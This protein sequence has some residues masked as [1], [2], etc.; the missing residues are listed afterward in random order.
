MIKFLSIKIQGFCSIADSLQLNLNQ[1]CT[2]LIKA[3]NGNG[4]TTLFSAIVWALYG[5][6]LKGISDVNTWTNVRPKDYSG[7]LVELFF[8]KGGSV[9]KVVRCQNCSLTLDD[10]AKGKDRLLLFKDSELVNVKGKIK[11]QETI[12]MELGLSYG[13]F[14]NS[15]MFGQGMKRLIQESNSDKKALFEEIFNLNFLNVAK[16]VAINNKAI[17]VESLNE[18]DGKCDELSRDIESNSAAYRDL[19]EVEKNFE[20]SIKEEREELMS[21][22]L[23]LTNRLI[24]VNGKYSEELESQ[25]KAKKVKRDKSLRKL[26]DELK[27]A[28][29]I[30]NT[31]LIDVIDQVYK[32][33]KSHEYKKA[34]SL[35]KDIRSAIISMD[36]LREQISKQE[37]L[38]DSVNQAL[39]DVEKYKRLASDIC[40]DI[41][42][43]D[44]QLSQLDNRKPKKL[45]INY[46]AKI[47]KLKLELKSLKESQ[48]RVNLET[49]LDNYNWLIQDP[50]GNNG[51]KAYLFDSSL[52]MV[53]EALHRY[54]DVLGFNIEFCIDLSTARKEFVTLI[55]RDGHIINY[56]ELS[57][58]ER[59]VCNIAMAFA[60]NEALTASKGIN[61]AFLD[62]V[63]ESLSHDN[64][65]IVISLINKV[66]EGKTLFLITH[67][68]SLP[69]TKSKVL[70]VEKVSGRS[71][72]KVL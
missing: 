55:E 49:A 60:M 72:Y 70:Q 13:L 50:L 33:I 15:I 42:S 14:M 63:F 52:N 56:D 65:E 11:T 69:L 28:K 19:L 47:K 12:D 66:F 41:A 20:A 4:K 36:D 40:D 59:Q 53:N 2:I 67:H 54:S 57:G 30:S 1:G 58:G 10:G 6:N 45:S 61:I 48:H 64:I 17:I 38:L 35:L 51:I 31:P 32:L 3:P 43:V 25:L 29:N 34:L 62:E 9:Y 16:E 8:Q 5:K 21:D 39:S 22:R 68:D 44:K 24:E 18:I 23:M 37:E 7:T 27:A 46:K 71:N 26:R